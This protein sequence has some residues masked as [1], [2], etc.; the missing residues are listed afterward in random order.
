MAIWKRFDSVETSIT[1]INIKLENVV[2]PKIEALAEGQKAILEMLV[3]RSRVDDLEEEMKL[4]K[5]VVR[6]IGEELQ[7]L[8]KAQ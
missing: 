6:Q 4:L 3:P 2:E 1:K 7:Q 8:R 5:I